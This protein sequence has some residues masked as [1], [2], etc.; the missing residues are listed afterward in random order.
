MR[1]RLLSATTYII[2]LT[3]VPL[4]VLILSCCK[5]HSIHFLYLFSSALLLAGLSFIM[6]VAALLFVAAALQG[7]LLTPF[8]HKSMATVGP[9]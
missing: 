9:H 5:C 8:G 6:K 1:A 3:L 4:I 7:E 2:Y